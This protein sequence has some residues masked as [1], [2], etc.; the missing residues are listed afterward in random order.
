MY[1]MFSLNERGCQKEE[2]AYAR[3][4][5]SRSHRN[6]RRSVSGQ[7]RPMAHVE[8]RVSERFLL[9]IGAMQLAQVHRGRVIYV[10]CEDRYSSIELTFSN[11]VGTTRATQRSD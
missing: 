8:F 4:H 7:I 9:Y 2:R 10:S 1:I 6:D 5:G 3:G 11:S